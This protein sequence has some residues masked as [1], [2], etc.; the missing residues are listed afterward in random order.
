MNKLT[1]AACL[2]VSAITVVTAEPARP[3]ETAP[4]A[5]V[6][7]KLRNGE[8]ADF[9]KDMAKELSS[10][11]IMKLMTNPD[12]EIDIHQHL[13]MINNAVIKGDIQLLN[14]EVP[15]NIALTNCVF[16]N[17]VNF[18][19]THFIRSLVFTGSTFEKKLDLE[20]VIIDYSF[21]IDTCQFKYKNPADPDDVAAYFGNV[22]VGRDLSMQ[23][24]A[25]FDGAADFTQSNVA[26]KLLGEATKFHSGAEFDSMTVA[27]EAIL[28]D[29]QFNGDAGFG[30][31]HFSNLFL[32]NAD[33]KGP[34]I[35]F[36]MMQV[37]NIFLDDVSYP[38]NA[39]GV[40]LQGMTFRSMSPASW[41]RLQNLRNHSEYDSEFYTSLETLFRSHGRTNEADRIFMEMQKHNRRENCRSLLHQCGGLTGRVRWIGSLLEDYLTGYGRRLENLLLWSIG[42]VLLGTL[43]FRRSAMK[44][45]DEPAYQPEHL[46]GLRFWRP[47]RWLNGLAGGFWYSLDLFLPIIE[48]GER[49]KWT[50]KDNRRWA[51]RYRRVHAIIGHLFVPI[52]LAA[53]TGIIK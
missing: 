51:L 46:T 4:E 6:L 12:Q 23:A 11:F 25:E 33:F 3:N 36:R 27:G 47:R 45:Q 38:P 15:N 13:I 43:V 14:E 41:E 52:G 48:L 34:V 21:T 2:L 17:D 40:L 37:D 49:D 32:S 39:A 9:P 29:A 28:R 30:K 42:F 16:E 7:D 53:W 22:R 24:G 1:F 5:Y 10:Q 26:G 31:T 20:N 18:T 8:P 50:P 19:Q 44:P 35:D